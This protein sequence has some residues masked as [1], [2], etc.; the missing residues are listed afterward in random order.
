MNSGNTPFVSVLMVTYNHE[1]FIAE[2]IESVLAS[3]YTDYELIVVD[4]RSSDRTAEIARAYEQKDSRV[5]VYVNEQN[6]GDYPNR[7]KAASYAKGQYLKYLDGD[8]IMYPHCIEVMVYNMIRCPDAAYGFCA[9]YSSDAPFPKIYTP[10]EAYRQ[11]FTVAPLFVSGPGATIIKK[12]CFDSANGFIEEKYIGDAQMWMKL[13]A[14]YDCVA[15]SAGLIWW[16]QYPQQESRAEILNILNS[17]VRHNMAIN[18]LL[19]KGCPLNSGEVN[20]AKGNLERLYIR[21]IYGQLIRLKFKTAYQLNQQAKLP[22][23]AFI[24]AFFP[25]NKFKRFF[26]LD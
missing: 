12:E 3:G 9:P 11:H 6:L 24:T 23:L 13:S 17:S 10:L 20:Q 7:N 25:V 21:R 4:D 2:A 15:F 16:R 1:L 8:D 18:M 26:G 22:W 19:A 14:K 5:K